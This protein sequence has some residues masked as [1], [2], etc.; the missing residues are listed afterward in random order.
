MKIYY[1][2]NPMRLVKMYKVDFEIFSIQR[3]SGI[4]YDL[5]LKDSG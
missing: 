5:F 4:L 1:T 3:N 2:K